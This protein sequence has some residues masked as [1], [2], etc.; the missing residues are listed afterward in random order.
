MVSDD[1]RA[2]LT[3][4]GAGLTQKGVGPELP[5]PVLVIA[6]NRVDYVKQTLDKLLE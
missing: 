2:E 3:K 4:R 6:C 1:K 5:M